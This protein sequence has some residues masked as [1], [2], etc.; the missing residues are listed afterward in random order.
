MA[1]ASEN[2]FEFLSTSK[3]QELR[4]LGLAE[5][6]IEKYNEL[7]K[8]K[9]LDRVRNYTY[10]MERP[11]DTLKEMNVVIL[12]KTGVG[13]STLGCS[14]LG[15]EFFR[16]SAK[17]TAE[18]KTIQYK[19]NVVERTKVRIIDTPG[20]M[21]TED[22][23]TAEVAKV[24]EI[25]DGVHVFVI[26]FNMA[27]TRFTQD[28]H[29]TMKEILSLFGEELFKHAIVVF[30]KAGAVIGQTHV[31]S[32]KKYIE[33]QRST[34]SPI[35]HFLKM[36]NYRAMAFENLVSTKFERD[37]QRTNLLDLMHST[38]FQANQPM[39]DNALFQEAQRRRQEENVR[40]FKAK[41]MKEV[42]NNADLGIKAVLENKGIASIYHLLDN[43]PARNQICQ[44]ALDHML[45]SL[46]RRPEYNLCD[47]SEFWIKENFLSVLKSMDEIFLE[48]AQK[49]IRDKAL[50]A[51]AKRIQ[52]LHK[53]KRIK[54]EE[55]KV[56]QQRITA[57]L[58]P[59]VKRNICQEDIKA[60]IEQMVQ[61]SSSE[62]E[63]RT[64][65]VNYVCV[66]PHSRCDPQKVYN[67]FN[68]MAEV[69]EVC[70]SEGLQLAI[71]V[72]DC[73]RGP[74]LKLV[75]QM[76]DEKI[77]E[78]KALEAK[79]EVTRQVIVQYIVK[80]D[81]RKLK[82][83]KQD[84]YQQEIGPIL[85]DVKSKIGEELLHYL[86]DRVLRESII[87]DLDTLIDNMTSRTWRDRLR[88]S[89]FGRFFMGSMEK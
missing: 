61:V 81:G 77:M 83:M 15:E 72:Q 26:V 59:A 32:L 25:F 89:R 45:D 76:K 23:V 19:Y 53:G 27:N 69:R 58:P 74:E 87:G 56:T 86:P 13:K 8:T 50:E 38:V 64:Q 34:T 18:T 29:G 6:Q 75:V 85:S 7:E 73:F 3:L 60:M 30:T 37:I 52:F 49:V 11:V 84:R 63:L 41:V 44:Q 2:E 1:H 10:C 4:Q 22:D 82:K 88:T 31:S 80:C 47:K 12:G 24:L 79:E 57:E 36:C 67:H 71:L 78:D 48:I 46:R 33:E 21:D 39:Y 42:R 20:F 35:N 68:A 16:T 9:I 14:L 17:V 40:K 55:I 65:I 51:L 43:Q 28:D 54:H 66:D 5:E 70:R 62:V